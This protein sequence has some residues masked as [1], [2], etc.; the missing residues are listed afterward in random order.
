[1]NNALRTKII[2]LMKYVLFAIAALLS[3]SQ[4]V[5]AASLSCGGVSDVGGNYAVPASGITMTMP[6]SGSTS[7][8]GFALLYTVDSA[9]INGSHI[10]VKCGDTS[11]NDTNIG[12]T[13]TDIPA[14]TT[15]TNGSYVIYPTT[16]EGIGVSFT[17]AMGS[18]STSAYT[19]WPTV[20]WYLTPMDKVWYNRGQVDTKLTIRVWKTPGY[21][22]KTGAL[23]FT[24][25]TFNEVASPY[26]ASDTFDTCPSSRLDSRTCIYLSRKIIGNAQF[27]SGTC[28][29]VDTVQTV[30]M[31]KFAGM[32]GNSE[33]KD[34]SFRLKCADAYGYGGS[35]SGA[36]NSNDPNDG[37]KTANNTQNGTVM[38]QILPYTTINDANRGIIELEPGGAEGY[39]LQLAWGLPSTQGTNPTNAVRIDT[40]INLQSLNTGFTLGPYAYGTNVLTTGA[41]NLVPL[42]A[43]YIRTSGTVVGGPANASIEILASYQ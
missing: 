33:W 40:P 10:N 11:T 25:P 17:M 16:V 13:V 3:T 31:G 6:N 39:G 37:T 34:A 35:V 14:G 36:L 4:L 38:I 5:S 32:G 2:L 23:S 18:D 20:A 42:S 1:M 26:N 29:I 28:D 41:D 43:R 22:L 21:T 27:V 8:G 30:Q 15:Y 24:G 9:L 7:N 19:A 12:F